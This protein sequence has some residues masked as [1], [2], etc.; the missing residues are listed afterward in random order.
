MHVNTAR[1]Y[2]DNMAIGVSLSD[3]TRIAVLIP[4]A[5]FSITDF[6]AC[7]IRRQIHC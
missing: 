7:I 5:S 1:I 4:I 2:R 3:S 6:V